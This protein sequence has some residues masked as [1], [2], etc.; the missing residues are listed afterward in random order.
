MALVAGILPAKIKSCGR[1]PTFMSMA[2]AFSGGLFLA[3]ALVH[4]L[5]E[6]T[7]EYNDWYDETYGGDSDNSHNLLL[8]FMRPRKRNYYRRLGHGD[9]DEPFVFPLPFVLVFSGYSFILLIDRVMF[10]SH[11]LF[12]GSHG[13]GHGHEHGDEKGHSHGHSD[14]HNNGKLDGR[15]N[16]NHINDIDEVTEI[17]DGKSSAIGTLK[18]TH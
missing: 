4:I 18:H 17:S 2:N 7:E 1:N 3:I 6:V 13:H 10:D 12:E 5:P 8:S 15:K 14:G 9:G 16:G 11:S